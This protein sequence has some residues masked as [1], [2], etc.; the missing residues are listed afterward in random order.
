MTQ[1]R[2]E[3]FAGAAAELRGPLGRAFCD[4]P[5][6]IATLGEDRAKRLARATRL[7]GGLAGMAQLSGTVEAIR[8]DGTIAAVSLSYGPDQKPRGRAQLPMILAGLSTGPRSLVR[9]LR[10]D[11]FLRTH[12]PHAPHFFL[13]VLGVE[14]ALQGRQLG[15]ALLGALSARADAAG[16]PCYLE[17]DREPAKRLYMRHG[18]QVVGEHDLTNLGGVRFWR[19][20]RPPA[21][22]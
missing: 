13:A 6:M 17:T 15:S 10:L 9:L 16:L 21:R 11:E 2:V 14:P 4:N 12:H 7:M 22:G 19:M 3:A 20:E 8:V 18:Y 5:G 1:P